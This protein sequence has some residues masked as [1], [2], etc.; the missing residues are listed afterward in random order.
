MAKSPK[1][2]TVYGRL[3]FPTFDYQMAVKKNATSQFAKADPAD[4]TPDF[5]LLLER[6]QLDKLKTHILD[7]FLPYCVEQEKK[8][9][10]RDALT[11]AQADKLRKL[12]ESEDWD[13]QPPYMPIKPV[14]DKTAE[15]APEALASVKILGNKGTDIQQQAIVQDE[16]ELAVPDPD[17]VDYPA[18]LPIAQTVHSL[19]GGCYA[20]ATLNLYAYISG[21]LPGFSAAASVC[22]FKADGDRFGGGVAIDEDEMFLD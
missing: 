6:A 2:V 19:Y 18:I 20:A 10:K 11:Q 1:N 3:S 4:V 7:E 9:E 8:N 13:S 21:K 14:S 22:V 12:I 17:R 16:S 5:N 15:L